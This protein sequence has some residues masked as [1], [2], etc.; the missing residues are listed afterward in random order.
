MVLRE[1]FARHWPVYLLGISL[2]IVTDLLSLL[3]PRAVGQAVDSIGTGDGNVT[4]A[5][6]LL[7]G[8]AVAMAVLRF[9]YRECIMG[10]TRRLEHFLREKLFHHALHL[11][12][13]IFDEAGPGK[14][15][16]LTV[17]DVA[18]VRVAIGLGIMLLVDAGVMGLISFLVMFRSIDPML[19]LWSVAPLPI[20][21]VLAAFLGRTV[22]ERFRK[23]QE[24]FS[25][26]TEFTQELFGGVKV[27][28]AFGVE[29]TLTDRFRNVNQENMAANLALARVQ[30]VYLPVTHVAPLLCYAVSLWIG[31]G[32]II[33]GTISVGELAAFTGYLGLIIWPVM[34]LGYLINTVQRGSASLMRLNDF[35]AIPP[36][37]I[38]DGDNT[39]ASGEWQGDIEFRGLTFQYPH[40]TTPSLQEVSLRIPSGSTIGIVGRTGSGK[41]TLLR[42]LLRLYPVPDGQLFVGGEDINRWDFVRLRAG[43]G[44]VPQDAALFSATIAENIMFG[45]VFERSRVQEAAEAAVV[46]EDIDSRAEGFGS[47]L[48]EKGTRLSGGQRQRVAIAR[49]L[50]RRPSLLL[51]DDVFAAL[52]YKTQTELIENLRE[53]EAGRT[54]LIVSQRVA[55][56]KHAGMIIVMDG[57]RI[58]ERGT[59]EDLIA[60]GGLYYRLYEQQL[61]AGDLS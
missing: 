5:L 15:M 60:A 44:Y 13:S 47:M 28:K 12:M 45:Q 25:V 35:L 16:A 23:V 38:T 52:D 34:G 27:I 40:A 53:I 57:G 22:H 11:P 18:S 48:G 49:A 56:V 59:H 33:A 19:T 42:L 8:V 24:K 21:F 10:T 26:L 50:I 46:R 7:A 9:L 61:A 43:V 20:V 14:I 17:N 36:Y 32:L 55:A 4:S 51:L 1:F 6:W 58:V 54:T 41:T 31:G 37:E 30:A 29:A 2:L 3:I 39:A